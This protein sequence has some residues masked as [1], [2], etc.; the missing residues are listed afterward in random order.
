V[1]WLRQH[2]DPLEDT[3]MEKY[4]HSTI[5]FA[6]PKYGY[7]SAVFFFTLAL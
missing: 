4:D 1:V 2:V 5:L 6:L 3:E 7:L